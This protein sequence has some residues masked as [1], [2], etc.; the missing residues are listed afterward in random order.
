MGL[1]NS[2]RENLLIAKKI[3]LPLEEAAKKFPMRSSVKCLSILDEMHFVVAFNVFLMS[4]LFM[5]YH[6]AAQQGVKADTVEL[7][8]INEFLM[9]LFHYFDCLGYPRRCVSKRLN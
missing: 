8:R 7:L 4:E 2:G 6:S 3:P 1:S 9:Q 5:A